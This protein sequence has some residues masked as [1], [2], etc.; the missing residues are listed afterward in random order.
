MKRSHG[1]SGANSAGDIITLNVGGTLHSTTRHLLV[2]SADYFPH[3]L[4]AKMFAQQSTDDTTTSNAL[5]DAD[6]HHFIDADWAVFRHVLQVLRR[7]SLVRDVP[8]KMS[9]EAWCRELDYWGLVPL[10]DVTGASVQRTG[11]Q[12]TRSSLGALLAGDD[13]ADGY[14]QMTLS[15]IGAAIK[16]EIMDNE[17]LVVRTLLSATGY[18]TQRGKTRSVVLR[19]PLGRYALPWGADMG[20]YL[21]ENGSVVTALLCD[22]L[23]VQA[24]KQEDGHVNYPVTIHESRTPKHHVEYQFDGRPYTTQEPTVSVTIHFTDLA[25]LHHHGAV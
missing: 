7:P 18:R 24:V 2:G 11:G 20:A 10:D 17:L 21:K 25:T 8:Y 3:S 22:M 12:L 13:A 5:I 4:L 6:G 19:V 14:E 23:D 9:A 16:K 15:E 1:D